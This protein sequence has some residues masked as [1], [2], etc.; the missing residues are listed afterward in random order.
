ME[1]LITKGVK[2]S[3]ETFYQAGHSNPMSNKYI[4][5]Y[6]VTIANTNDFTVQLLRR[7][8]YIQ[9]TNGGL[10]EVEGEGVVGKQPVLEP[11]QIHRYV[12]WSSLPTDI[13]KMYGTF[14]MVRQLDSQRFKVNI[15]EFKLIAPF[16]RN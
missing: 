7:H 8:W 3:V 5:A 2:I 11:G 6:R 9:D 10:R 15:P 1:T 12:S 14:S 16:K 4:H 13:G